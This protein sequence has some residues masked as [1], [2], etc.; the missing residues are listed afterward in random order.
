MKSS[1]EARNQQETRL[2]LR[3]GHTRLEVSTRTSYG[4]FPRVSDCTYR[5]IFLDLSVVGEVAIELEW[6][7]NSCPSSKCEI[8][9]YRGVALNVLHIIHRPYQP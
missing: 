7:P 3:A 4:S 9:G 5:C 8:G 1:S 6:E 2:L